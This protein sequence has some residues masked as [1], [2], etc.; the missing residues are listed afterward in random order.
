M[1]TLIFGIVFGFL[2]ARYRF[3][4]FSGFRNLFYFKDFSFVSALSFC[5]FLQSL[6][7]FTLEHFKLITIPEF[8]FSILATIIGSF[9]FGVGMAFSKACVSGSFTRVINNSSYLITAFSFA[10]SMALFN[11]IFKKYIDIFTKNEL[12]N[13]HTFLNISPFILVILLGILSIYLI[14]K[15]KKISILAIVLAI[16]SLLMWKM[17]GFSFTLSVP[18]KNMIL[19]LVTNQYRYLDSG[20]YFLFGC[21]L[22]GIAAN[23]KSFSL[24]GVSLKQGYF[25][26]IGGFLMAFGASLASGCNVANILIA[27][28]YFS[29]QAFIFLP[30]MLFGF[31]IILRRVS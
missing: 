18:S 10:F 8:K 14:Y 19:Y 24:Q 21:I 4:F 1:N 6:G 26:V 12:T 27:S 17:I 16:L 5:I 28:A 11:G 9:A 15:A 23:L 13:I 2:L 31:L 3:C 20:V 7:L 29:F 30:F 25:S 22:G